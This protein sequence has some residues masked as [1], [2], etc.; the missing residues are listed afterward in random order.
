MYKNTTNAN[1]NATPTN[2]Q[3]VLKRIHAFLG[4]E[5]RTYNL[6][7]EDLAAILEDHYPMFEETSGWSI[8]GD[9]ECV[10]VGFD[11]CVLEFVVCVLCCAFCSLC[12]A[13]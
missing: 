7:E 11:F 1:A 5:D 4:L 10:V 13:F 3:A 9:Y 6:S 8:K 12:F 2:P